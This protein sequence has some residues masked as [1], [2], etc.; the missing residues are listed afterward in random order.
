MAAAPPTA[1]LPASV[2]DVSFTTIEQLLAAGDAFGDHLASLGL[3]VVWG[4][5]IKN[6]GPMRLDEFLRS[7]DG[8]AHGTAA[9]AAALAADVLWNATAAGKPE[10]STRQSWPSP[11]IPWK[12]RGGSAVDVVG[13][14]SVS[15]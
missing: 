10:R 2:V 12:L 4:W 3:A 5:S 15:R 14:A 13:L 6:E 8:V 11:S 7:A 1:S 9:V